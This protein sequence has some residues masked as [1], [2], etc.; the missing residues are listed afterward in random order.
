MGPNVPSVM[1]AQV[2]LKPEDQMGLILIDL[3]GKGTWKGE[4][5]KQ[6]KGTRLQVQDGW[7]SYLYLTLNDK[8][9]YSV[10]PKRG[11]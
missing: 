7:A 9:I 3:F 11:K 10:Y 1:H 5:D 6:R 8:C 4:F 2:S